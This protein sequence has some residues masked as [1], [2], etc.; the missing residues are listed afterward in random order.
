[1]ANVTAAAH[2]VGNT[3]FTRLFIIHIFYVFRLFEIKLFSFFL[4]HTNEASH[5]QMHCIDYSLEN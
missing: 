4:L 1:M 5:Q 3:T 2:F